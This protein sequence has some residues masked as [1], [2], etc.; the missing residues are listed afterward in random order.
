MKKQNTKKW[1]KICR[2]CGETFEI[3]HNPKYNSRQYCCKACKKEG[4]RQAHN[5]AQRMYVKRYKQILK[6]RPERGSN[7][8][9]SNLK[10]HRLESFEEEEKQ[11]KKELKRL[12]LTKLLY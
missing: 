8:G 10:V 1:I 12:G 11:I 3:P 6:E 9:N 2:N 4:Y 7:L 5:N